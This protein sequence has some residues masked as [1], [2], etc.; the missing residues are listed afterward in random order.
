M[1][2]SKW[3]VIA[4]TVALLFSAWGCGAK[5][6]LSAAELLDLGE[7]YLLEM[8][9]EQAVVCFTKLIAI[10]PKNPRGYTGLA[11]AYVGLG[12]FDKALE[13][14]RQGLGQL[15]DSVEIAELLEEL[16][17]SA[18]ESYYDTLSDEQK[19]MLSR[20]EAALR[21]TDY[22]TAYDI[23]KTAEF[24]VLC[25]AIPKDWG[26]SFTYYP[27]SETVVYVFRGDAEIEY[28]YNM[29]LFPGVN[30]SGRFVDSRYGGYTYTNY[31]MAAASYSNG[32]ANGPFVYYVFD[33]LHNATEFHTK[34]GNLRDGA[35]Y[36]PVMKTMNG[37]TYEEEYV[38]E[39]YNWWPDWPE[40]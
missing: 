36:G 14:L 7:K 20:L 22:Q 28:S 27:D 30:G 8:N 39:W 40:R 37:E 3:C 35:A 25:D 21:A 1:K 18:G 6:Q 29:Q 26:S 17:A 10:E 13:I 11:E 24:H 9:Y 15:P 32:A 5:T 38:P 33:Y 12:E 16:E 19:Q 23:Q 31:C 34:Q 4:L 2:K